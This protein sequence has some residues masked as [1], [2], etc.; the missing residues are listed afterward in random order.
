MVRDTSESAT[1]ESGRNVGHDTVREGAL[2]PSPRRPH[3][4]GA[5]RAPVLFIAAAAAAAAT[6]ISSLAPAIKPT[7]W[8]AVVRSLDCH[9]SLLHDICFALVLVLV[10]VLAQ[11]G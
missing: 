7:P 8:C 6:S 4:A 2:A 5:A 1:A 3:C 10:L 9:P 11:Y